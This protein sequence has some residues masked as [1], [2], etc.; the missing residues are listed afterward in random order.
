MH[1]DVLGTVVYNRTI[2]FRIYIPM[3]RKLSYLYIHTTYYMPFKRMQYT[4]H[5]L[6]IN[7]KGTFTMKRSSRYTLT[8]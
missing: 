4:P 8:K 7:R 5:S 6:L 3:K 1:I 2:F